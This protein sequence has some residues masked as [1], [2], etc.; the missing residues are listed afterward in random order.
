[1][2][3][4]SLDLLDRLVAFPTVSSAS[5]RELIAF[6]EAFLAARG[7]EAMLVPNADGTKA[8][9]F[10]TIGPRDTGGV[11]LSGHTD[12]VPVEGQAW[13]GDPFRLREVGGRLLGR[14]TTDMKGF[15]AC[16]LAAADRAA[17]M[18][19][20]LPLHLA[21][22]YDEEIGCIGVRGLIDALALAPFRPQM[23][24]IGEPTA[25]AVATGHKGKTALRALCCGREAHSA[26]AP[27]ALNAIHLAA[28][29][30]DKIRARQ[31][32]YARG[33]ARDAAY[34]VPY[35]TFHVGRIAGG[36]ALNIVPNACTLELEFRNLAEDD[37]AT[38]LAELEADAE[39]VAL[40]WTAA[41]PEAAVKLEATNSYP[42]LATADDAP[43]VD[44]TRSLTGSNARMKLAFGTE[45][46]LFQSRLSIPTVVCGPGS[47]DQGHKPDEWVAR[48]QIAACDHFMDALL[49]RLSA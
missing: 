37:P 36:T 3:A 44:F 30:V 2:S 22:S 29:F 1:M 27:T 31:A 35:S 33:G 16:A 4:R 26:L 49:A 15:L 9:L 46:G 39:A 34:D 17:R 14:G 12:V 13:S 45:G 42:G 20:A 32:L 25:M 6:V 7:I 47:M 48:D 28:A 24:I 23:A 8:N 38:L 43:V 10:A 18:E 40:P 11:M 5:N 21:L 19:L 41:F